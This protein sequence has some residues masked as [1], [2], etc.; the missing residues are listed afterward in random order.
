MYLSPTAERSGCDKALYSGFV[1]H[2]FRNRTC[3]IQLHASLGVNITS[4]LS[5]S[6]PSEGTT[7]VS[8]KSLTLM[9]SLLQAKNSCGSTASITLVDM[10]HGEHLHGMM[11]RHDDVS[12]DAQIRETKSCC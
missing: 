4:E 1:L 10:V 12:F 7:D 5:R 3:L 11:A 8:V 2:R 6:I 9:P